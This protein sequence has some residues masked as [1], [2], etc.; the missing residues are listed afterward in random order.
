MFSKPKITTEWPNLVLYRDSEGHV[1]NELLEKMKGG[2]FVEGGQDYT[3]L[4][5]RHKLQSSGIQT[6]DWRGRELAV[7]KSSVAIG[8]YEG[9]GEQEYGDYDTIKKNIPG[10]AKAGCWA[11]PQL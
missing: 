7:A 1:T 3:T 4:R 5:V 2:K 10:G 9:T 11:T 6:D 8:S